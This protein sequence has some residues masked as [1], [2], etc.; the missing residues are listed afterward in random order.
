MEDIL[1]NILTDNDGFDGYVNDYLKKLE[2]GNYVNV[3][4]KF[5]QQDLADIYKDLVNSG[6]LL[7][8]I[9]VL[10]DFDKSQ[11]YNS[12]KHGY[13]HNERVIF[14]AFILSMMQNVND[15][16]REIIMDAAKYHDIGRQNNYTDDFHGYVGANKIGNIVG[17]K[18]IYQNVDNLNLLKMVIDFHASKDESF[19][20]DRLIEY[21]IKDIERAKLI[22]SILKDADALDRVRLSMGRNNSELDPE[23]LR[24]DYAKTLTKAS[25]QLNEIYLRYLKV[26]DGNMI[27]EQLTK[28]YGE[29]ICFHGI[30][31]NFFV[32]YNIL[33]HGILSYSKLKER[34]VISVRNYEG[35]NLEDYI[36]V[37]CYGVHYYGPNTAFEEHIKNKISFCIADVL[38]YEGKKTRD[39]YVHEF[40]QKAI[41]FPHDRGEFSD[42]RFVKD[43]IPLS[44]IKKIIIPRHLL[45]MKLDEIYYMDNGFSL[46]I[47][48]NKIEYYLENIESFSLAKIDRSIFNYYINNIKNLNDK[49]DEELNKKL[50]KEGREEVIK[51]Y[52]ENMRSI[53][54]K[55]NHE[56]GSLLTKMYQIIL[57][58]EE[59]VV[60]DVIEYILKEHNREMNFDTAGDYLIIDNNTIQ[61]YK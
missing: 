27:F 36:S 58:K 40:D 8:L 23:K 11:L 15:I 50:N 5:E 42:E 43:E 24:T 10:K 38:L 29:D 7:N 20:D 26:K 2:K 52:N 49:L 17:Y 60:G 61:K 3:L 59:I 37:A 54:I 18:A 25:H 32:F 1:I 14:F 6:Q 41:K 21:E 57:D 46:K 47:I 44:H 35:L 30:G 51:Q 31:L 45:S 39:Y 9:N 16:D 53:L 4:S 13:M 33:K 19:F 22:C 28:E 12:Y 34:G 48:S 55:I 56:I